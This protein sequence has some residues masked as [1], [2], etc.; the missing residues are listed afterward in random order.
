[1]AEFDTIIKG[2]TVIDGWLSAY[3]AMAAGFKDRGWIKEGSPADIVIYDLENLGIGPMEKVYDLPAGQWRRVR[4][5]EG[6]RWILV[7][8]KV[9]MEDGETTGATPGR[10]LRYG[11]G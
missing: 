7:N 11:A 5:A 4:R 8:G 2:G 3:P 10:L 1:M 6:Y 9:T